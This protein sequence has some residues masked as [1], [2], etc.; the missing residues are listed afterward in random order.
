[1]D[2][3]ESSP[4][5]KQEFEEDLVECKD[6][7]LEIVDNLKQE[8]QYDQENFVSVSDGAET[9]NISIKQ[10]CKEDDPLNIADD[11]DSKQEVQSTQNESTN[12]DQKNFVSVSD[13]AELVDEDIP[14][15]QLP[16]EQ[17]EDMFQKYNIPFSKTAKTSKLQWY[18]SMMIKRRHPLN[19]QLGVMTNKELKIFHTKL[20]GPPIRIGHNRKR[21]QSAIR[22]YYFKNH[23]NAPLTSFLKD[24]ERLE[25]FEVECEEDD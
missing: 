11:F 18:L 6:E 9:T 8:Q 12:S 4:K 22:C 17:L 19:K 21:F 7:L 24:K 20:L 5:I 14:L 15:I 2:N 3:A 25:N 10:E 1:M 23:R 16:R 13:D